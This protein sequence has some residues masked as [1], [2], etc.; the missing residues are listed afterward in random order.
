MLTPKIRRSR[1]PLL[2]A[3]VLRCLFAVLALI[4][5][6]GPAVR[7]AG[8]VTTNSTAALLAAVRG[9]GLVQIALSDA[10][11]VE[12]PIEIGL[13]TV[14]EGSST[15]GRTAIFSGGSA[16]RIFRVL[17]GVRFAI[18]NCTLREGRAT[19]GGA[20]FNE[21]I[22]IASNVVFSASKAIG[23]A[24]VAGADGGSE[25]GFGDDGENGTSGG[26]AAGGAVYSTGEATFL[27]C[28]FTANSAEGG[29]GGKG[30]AGG[31]GGTH[32]GSGGSGGHGGAAFGGAVASTGPLAVLR[33]LFTANN[34]GGGDA[35]AGGAVG[36]TAGGVGS[37][38]G[39]NGG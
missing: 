26:E 31:A 7:A 6:P 37:G 23:A 8:T 29:D 13:D 33:S 25:F 18:Q 22:L 3:G 14:I 12:I 16:R 19:S 4:A 5:A 36:T 1:S 10:I 11:T 28:T 30:G 34:A 38:S 32:S 9:G 17:P 21:G 2:G 20:I 27:D 24:G 39:G 35:G 15:S